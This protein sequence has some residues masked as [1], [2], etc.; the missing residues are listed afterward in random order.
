MIYLFF[1]CV[2]VHVS[3]CRYVSVSVILCLC[4][5]L[6][7]SGKSGSIAKGVIVCRPKGAGGAEEQDEGEMGGAPG[8]LRAS[9]PPPSKAPTSPRP[10][11]FA[12]QPCANGGSLGASALPASSMMAASSAW[13]TYRSSSD[14]EWS[15]EGGHRGERDG[16][17]LE[18]AEHVAHTADSIAAQEEQWLREREVRS[19]TSIAAARDLSRD[20]A[21]DLSRGVAPRDMSQPVPPPLER[22]T[23]GSHVTYSGGSR[24]A[25]G[26]RDG[27]AAAAAATHQ[28]ADI[29]RPRARASRDNSLTGLEESGEL[30]RGQGGQAR[31]GRRRRGSDEEWKLFL[32]PMANGKHL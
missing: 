11:P 13:V 16:D 6:R 18:H 4:L 7:A 9:K 14:D 12:S 8:A 30:G 29:P 2:C 19:V 17:A 27:D 20:L 15:Q 23:A 21:R 10:Y 24:E 1:M 26:V 32:G 31:G 22:P 28:G 25:D 3:V 5:C